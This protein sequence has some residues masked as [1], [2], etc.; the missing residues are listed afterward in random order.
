M[1]K[2]LLQHTDRMIESIVESLVAYSLS[3]ESS[4]SDQE[5]V[6]RMVRHSRESGYRLPPLLKAFVTSNTFTGNPQSP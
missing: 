6:A 5:V 4:F 2:G 1:R 3:R